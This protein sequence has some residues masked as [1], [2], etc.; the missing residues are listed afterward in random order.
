MQRAAPQ[1]LT[2]QIDFFINLDRVER[3][4]VAEMIHTLTAGRQHV[5]E[6]VLT[7]NGRSLWVKWIDSG[8]YNDRGELIEIESWGEVVQER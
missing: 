6:H 7:M 1:R 8:V 2:H 4:L 5:S 3:V